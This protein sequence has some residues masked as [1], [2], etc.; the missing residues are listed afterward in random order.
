MSSDKNLSH[1]SD[2]MYTPRGFMYSIYG[3]LYAISESLFLTVCMEKDN[4]SR[5]QTWQ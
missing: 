4:R 3:R 5:R 1:G 2:F